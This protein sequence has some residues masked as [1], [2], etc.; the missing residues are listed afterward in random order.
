M[1]GIVYNGTTT[2]LVEGLELRAPGP[3]DVIVEIGAAGLCHS[4]LSY[5]H[6]LYPVPSPAVCGHE[7]AGVV[8]EVGN[9]VT[10]VR[11]GDHVII[12]TLAACGM[13]EFCADGRPTACR[14][15]LANWSQP[16]TLN[17]ESIYNFAATSAFAERTVVRD[18]QCVKIPDD[19]PLTSAAIV[20]CGV[21]TGMGAVFNRANVKRGQS[22]AVFGVGGVGLN[23]I[24]ALKV[25]GATTIIAIDTVPEKEALARQFGATHFLDGTRDDLVEAIGAIR[26]ASETAPRG[27]FNSGGVNWAFDCVANPAVTWNALESLDWEG[28]VVVIG[29]ASQTAEFKG[30]YGRLT[31][32]DRG[33]IGCR[34]GTISPHRDIPRIIEL[35]RRGEVRLD[36]LVTAS[37]KIDDWHDAVAELEAGAVARGVLTF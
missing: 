3:R 30:L 33:I 36:E 21:V 16:F 10:N 9:A 18:I 32:V 14:S 31:Q 24:Q 5:M 11:P 4:D 29:V 1:R 8:T 28:T 34:Y 35:Y 20:G 23:V 12:A 7:G 27:A 26:P 37:H 22:A 13:C 15:T 25:Q 17:G 19:V 6:G 2:E